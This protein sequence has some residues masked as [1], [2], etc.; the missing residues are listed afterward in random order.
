MKRSAP[1]LGRRISKSFLAWQGDCESQGARCRKE[2]IPGQGTARVN[3]VKG[4][5]IHSALGPFYLRALV[6]VGRNEVAGK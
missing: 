1:C 6:V 5:R 3:E 2:G 4:V